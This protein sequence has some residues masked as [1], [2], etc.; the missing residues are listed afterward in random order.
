MEFEGLASPPQAAQ[1]KGFDTLILLNLYEDSLK[2]LGKESSTIESYSR[3]A[4]IFLGYLSI[5]RLPFQQVEPE[6]LIHFQDYLRTQRLEKENSVRRSVI[7][8][9]QFYRF[10]AA[11]KIVGSSPFD[12]IPIP[13]RDE[14]LGNHVDDEMLHRLLGEAIK[15]RPP[16]KSSRDCAILCLLGFEGIKANELI[17]LKW[18]DLFL[19][20][21]NPPPTPLNST[22]P[23]EEPL[24][25]STLYI[26]GTRSRVLSLTSASAEALGTYRSHYENSKHP[27]LQRHHENFI[28][29][30]F[31][32]REAATPLPSM[33]RHG[34]KFLLYE[35]GSTCDL[36]HLNTEQ[37]RH[38]AVR[39]LLA[40]GKTM[41]EIM[42][43]L[44]LRRP[45]NIT[46]HLI[47]NLRSCQTTI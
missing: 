28:F 2:S 7:G 37:L 30:A 41:D 34:L 4:R 16:L 25:R 31:K 27:A 40:L 12:E 32:G 36:P 14:R 8:I 42:V 43:H 38:H 18:K 47:K 45:G 3:D 29:C 23:E 1:P 22:P 9:R 10:L 21:F 6:T 46:K 19:P 39:F 35:I 11:K 15:I 44:G 20:S 26:R 5:N 24:P 17:A 33:T 13:A